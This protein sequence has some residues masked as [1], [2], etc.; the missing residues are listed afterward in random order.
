MLVVR[1]PVLGAVLIDDRVAGTVAAL[2]AG[3]GVTA[4]DGAS[5]GPLFN[6]LLPRL[7]DL[8]GGLGFGAAR[9]LCSDSRWDWSRRSAWSR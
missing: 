2:L 7:Q 4:F 6:D 9:A 3:I 8:F 1:P 5:E